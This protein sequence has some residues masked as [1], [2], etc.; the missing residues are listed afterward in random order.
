MTEP[1]EFKYTSSQKNA[2]IF[3]NLSEARLLERDRLPLRL[4]DFEL[5]R[6]LLRRRERDRLRRDRDRDRRD[7]PERDRD[8]LR[9]RRLDRERDLSK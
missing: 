3:L 9:D 4:R 1:V 6:D 2:K 5:L 7:P 8:R